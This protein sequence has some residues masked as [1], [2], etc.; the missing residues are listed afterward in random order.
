MSRTENKMTYRPDERREGER[1]LPFDPAQLE[2][3]AGVVFIGLVR[4]PWLSREECPK[5]MAAAREAARP[6]SIEMDRRYCEGL[7]G[8]A[9]YS[10]IAVL[11]WLDRA[12]RNLIIQKPRH[13][14]DPKGVFALRSPAR[15]NPIGLHIVRLVSFDAEAGILALEAIDAL[16][17]TPVIDIKP[18]FASTDAVPDATRPER[19]A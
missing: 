18:Y 16:D 14:T 8:L 9:G 10:H 3:D 7:H 15:P 19:P 1:A 17:G 4:S 12:P 13:A 5:N 6:A 2:P 11:T